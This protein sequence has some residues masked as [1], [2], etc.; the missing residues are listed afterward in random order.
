MHFRYM[1]GS[2][3][4]NFQKMAQGIVLLKLLDVMKDEVSLLGCLSCSFSRK[5]LSCLMKRQREI[6]S[7]HPYDFCGA[8]SKP[9]QFSETR[10]KYMY[11]HIY[12]YLLTV[13]RPFLVG[14]YE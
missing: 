6:L 11:T 2:V 7:L 13:S 10:V 4:L 9:H 5:C 3:Q 8:N 12:I 1:L 14:M